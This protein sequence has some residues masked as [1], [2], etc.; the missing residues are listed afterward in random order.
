ME[1]PSEKQ[2]IQWEIPGLLEKLR[3]EDSLTALQND[4]QAF[5][6]LKV[7]KEFGAG[8]FW[9]GHTLWKLSLLMRQINNQNYL[10]MNV[11]L[12]HNDA[13]WKELL[14]SYNVTLLDAHS[15][16]VKEFC[17]FESVNKSKTARRFILSFP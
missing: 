14:A 7:T 1:G 4:N 16:I 11:E 15:R 13:N 2:L 10:G 3:N 9:G 5:V 17:K 8:H 12:A 6:D